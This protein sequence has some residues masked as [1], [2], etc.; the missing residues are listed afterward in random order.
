MAVINGTTGANR[1]NGTSGHDTINP[2]RGSDYVNGGAGA[3]V[4]IWNQDP[5]SR[6]SIDRYAGGSTGEN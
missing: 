5:Y 3:D 6:D 2:G 4:L 1:L